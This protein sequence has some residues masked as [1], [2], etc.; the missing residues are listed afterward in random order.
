M[1]TVVGL[2]L[3]VALIAGCAGTDDSGLERLRA[4]VEELETETTRTTTTTTAPS[5]T[6]VPTP[7]EVFAVVSPS[8]VFID[9]PDGSSGSGILLSSG[10]VVTNAHVVGHFPTVRLFTSSGE[11]TEVPVYA[12]DWLSVLALIGPLPFN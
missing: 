6:A 11:F 9:V 1:R 10:Y 3:A 2:L 12:R 4:R 7:A 5:T 8:V